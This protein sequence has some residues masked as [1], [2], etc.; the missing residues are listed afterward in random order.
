MRENLFFSKILTKSESVRF[1]T[2][3][4]PRPLK[5]NN[6]DEYDDIDIDDDD[7]YH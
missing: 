6:D 4:S 7:D 2:E 3:S 5:Y 1:G